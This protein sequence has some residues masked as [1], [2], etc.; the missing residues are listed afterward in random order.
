MKFNI[1]ALTISTI[2]TVI[3]ITLITIIGELSEPFKNLLK[4][5]FGHHWIAK[6]VFSLVLFIG[7]YCLLSK[8]NDY[9]FYKNQAREVTIA[10]ILS[11]LV[12]LLF[13][14][15]HFFKG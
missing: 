4:D 11:S 7:L 13:F 2:V 1:K 8:I 3:S 12:L 6:S 15:W 9:K 14:T 5:T 10:V